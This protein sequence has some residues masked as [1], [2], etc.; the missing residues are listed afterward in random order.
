MYIYFIFLQN[1]ERLKKVF[2]NPGVVEAHK[3]DN[4]HTHKEEKKETTKK[5]KSASTPEKKLLTKKAKSK[6]VAK[7]IKKVS[8]K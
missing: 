6:P 7:K 4:D 8:K 5:S 3:H 1:R 2:S